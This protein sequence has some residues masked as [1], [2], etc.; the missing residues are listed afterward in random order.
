MRVVDKRWRVW[1][2][3]VCCGDGG[4]CARG[5]LVVY[6]DGNALFFGRYFA[7][8]FEECPM[9]TLYIALT[10]TSHDFIQ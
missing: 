10:L 3:V 4:E 9:H 7:A 2:L 6:G 1:A 8:K 5:L